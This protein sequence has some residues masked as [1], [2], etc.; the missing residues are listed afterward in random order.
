MVWINDITITNMKK[1]VAEFM[2]GAARAMQIMPST[3]EFR[4]DWKHS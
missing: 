2:G 3:C 1:E 4:R